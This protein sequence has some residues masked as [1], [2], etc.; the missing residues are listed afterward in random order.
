ML[1]LL[2]ETTRTAFLRPFAYWKSWDWHY[3]P[4]GMAGPSSRGLLPDESTPVPIDETLLR[5]LAGVNATQ[6]L[7]ARL[8]E[9]N[10]VPEV[11]PLPM[12]PAL[13]HYIAER[14]LRR[15][16]EL[17]L[18]RHDRDRRALVWFALHVHPDAWHHARLGEEAQRRLAGGADMDWLY[19]ERALRPQ[20]ERALAVLADAFLEAMEAERA[21]ANR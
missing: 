4:V 2:P 3:R 11:S 7:I 19:D 18:V 16:E 1:S 10:P 21:S 13:R 6:Y 5:S 20:G 14:E 17:G 8:E 9:E 15:A 12:N